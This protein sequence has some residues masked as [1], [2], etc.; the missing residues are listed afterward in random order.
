MLDRHTCQIC[1][2]LEIMLLLL[3]VVLYFTINVVYRGRYYEKNKAKAIDCN[4][5]RLQ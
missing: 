4:V 2:P 5:A 3:V 1:Y